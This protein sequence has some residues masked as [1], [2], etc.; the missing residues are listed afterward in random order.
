MSDLNR[1]R[2]A[3]IQLV[4]D[5]I[6]L[7]IA[8]NVA[9]FSQL[10]A[11]SGLDNE[12]DVIRRT[13]AVAI[14]LCSE[15]MRAR[16]LPLFKMRK[17]RRAELV[18]SMIESGFVRTADAETM[19]N[20]LDWACSRAPLESDSSRPSG[21][22]AVILAAYLLRNEA[23]SGWRRLYNLL[24]RA[25]FESTA[26]PGSDRAVCMHCLL[27]AF[28]SG[29]GLGTADTADACLH[30]RGQDCAVGAV[31]LGFAA[32]GRAASA[33]GR[34]AAARGMVKFAPRYKAIASAYG[35]GS[36]GSAGWA[37]YNESRR[38]RWI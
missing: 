10:A 20:M 14:V 7:V 3:D 1:F 36:T 11:R 27:G 22:L 4:R 37:A 30:G 29:V 33:L 28:Y 15:T 5:L 9:E 18:A 34:R 21:T 32:E 13:Y 16:I 26:C 35:N 8:G 24:T 2:D 12:P 38:R 23:G 25:W 19:R 17:K 31:S 6:T